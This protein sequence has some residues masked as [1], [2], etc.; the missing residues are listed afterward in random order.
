MKTTKFIRLSILLSLCCV[1]I[2]A[3]FTD[4]KVVMD[5]DRLRKS[6]NNELDIFEVTIQNYL[7]TTEFAPDAMDIE[8]SIELHFFLED[9]SERGNEKLFSTQIL[10]H[11]GLDQQYFTKGVEF[12]YYP[13][14]NMFYNVQ[15]ESLRSIIDYYAFLIIAGDLDTYDL[16]GGETYYKKTEE[17]ALDG[18]SFVNF[19][20]SNICPPLTEAISI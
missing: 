14:K 3:Q 10:V 8:F 19:C 11:N 12:S 1:L 13:G 20:N 17:I 15:F 6:L 16:M 9:I 5:T 7:L 4:A 2:N 18:K